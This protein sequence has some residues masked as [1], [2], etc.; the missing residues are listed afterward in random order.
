MDPG[1][2]CLY[3]IYPGFQGWRVPNSCKPSTRLNGQAGGGQQPGSCTV[4]T[5]KAKLKVRSSAP[6]LI[7]DPKITDRPKLE[8]GD[9]DLNQCRHVTQ[10]LIS[11]CKETQTGLLKPD[12]EVV[13]SEKLSLN[14][15]YETICLCVGKC[16]VN[17]LP[18]KSEFS[19]LF[20]SPAAPESDKR[21][22]TCC[23]IRLENGE[24]KH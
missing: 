6:R 23:Q 22:E 4:Y 5:R 7:L 3:C 2:I 20:L 12:Y 16:F 24:G 1:F 13:P 10:F 15:N 9:A 14:I 17:C 8:Y 21:Q 18:K 11:L 19:R